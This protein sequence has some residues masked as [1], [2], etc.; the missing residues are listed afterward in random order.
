MPI[1]I[2]RTTSS[3]PAGPGSG[4][5]RPEVSV[6]VPTAGR[7]DAIVRVLTALARQT[8][9]PARFEVVV[10]D[11]GSRPPVLQ[12]LA[13]LE[14]PYPLHCEWQPQA[15]PAAA[16][17]RAIGRARGDL[18]LIVN[19]DAGPPP[20]L[21]ERHLAAHARSSQPRAWLGEFEFAP[22]CRTPFAL[23]I[24]RMGVVFPFSQMRREGPNPGRFFWTCNLSVPR[25]AVL[26][27][28]GFDESFRRPICE[29]VELGLR[30]EKRGV[31]VHF[32]KG[33]ACLHHHRVDVR[34]LERHQIDLGLEMVRIWRKHGDSE[35]LPWLNQ[36]RGDP[37]ILAVALEL[38]A[39]A[40][41]RRAEGSLRE[42]EAI[43]SA[44]AAGAAAEAVA[45]V[46]VRP[47]QVVND[48]SLRLGILA[49][50]RGLSAA[51]ILRWRD[52]LPPLTSLCS[53]G[54]TPAQR[55]LD[56]LRHL[57]GA[58]VEWVESEE[59]AAGDQVCRVD[60]G[61]V[62]TRG[63]L[64]EALARLA[65]ATGGV[66]DEPGRFRLQRR[67]AAVPSTALALTR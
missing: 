31:A 50:L 57:A 63:W 54:G 49:G 64:S 47:I 61:F 46:L 35:L 16:R 22:D 51:E 24:T 44:V 8:V 39:T 2:P 10:T 9:G 33:A 59:L 42:V 26:D 62:P 36:V 15:G 55:E 43:D 40:R 14:L 23:A 52:E 65:R 66:V 11:D 60:P 12:R 27:A 17:N 1:P 56:R 53:P 48:D 45:G 28:G 20:D 67:R 18:L 6:I 19:D 7:P 37:E 32:L 13:E 25:R 58:P 3:S 5:A 41:G 21:I 38:E 30:L 29:D 34:W 4:P